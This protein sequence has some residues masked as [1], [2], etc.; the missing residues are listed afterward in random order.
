MSENGSA[1]SS[2]CSPCAEPSF[3]FYPDHL[4]RRCLLAPSIGRK[5]RKKRDIGWDTALNLADYQLISP[6]VSLPAQSSVHATDKS[7]HDH[8][9][10]YLLSITCDSVGRALSGN[11]QLLHASVRKRLVTIAIEE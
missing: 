1:Q 3:H 8:D 9:T 6:Q 7:Q 10:V 11:L 2:Q 4:I 5:Q